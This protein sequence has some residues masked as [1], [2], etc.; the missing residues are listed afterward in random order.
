MFLTGAVCFVLGY[1]FGIVVTRLARS[2][3]DGD[4]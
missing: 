3:G 4:R 2:A 1:F